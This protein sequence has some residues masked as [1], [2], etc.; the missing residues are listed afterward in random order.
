MTTPDSLRQAA[1]R[2]FK[3]YCNNALYKEI[4]IKAFIKDANWAKTN[5]Y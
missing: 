2:S 4:Y 1:S 5:K 3:T